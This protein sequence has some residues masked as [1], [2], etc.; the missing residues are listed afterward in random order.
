MA[1]EHWTG[2]EKRKLKTMTIS[3][4]I[5]SRKRIKEMIGYFRTPGASLWAVTEGDGPFHVSKEL[6]RK[7]RKYVDDDDLDW[8]MDENPGHRSKEFDSEWR[9]WLLSRPEE[10]SGAVAVYKDELG[11][12]IQLTE[13]HFG[14]RSGCMSPK[15]AYGPSQFPYIESI[16]DRDP[17]L[18]EASKEFAKA[19]DKGEI[20]KAKVMCEMLGNALIN[21]IA[22]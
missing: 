17:E 18:A 9:E 20:A 19:L 12:Q 11:L 1:A 13:V 5:S 4:V 10:F 16:F 14:L 7:I 8:V 22:I 6:G 2:E 15:V 21:R 3:P